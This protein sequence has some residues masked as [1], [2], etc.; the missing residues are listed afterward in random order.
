MD[1]KALA[2]KKLADLKVIAQ[3]IGL[4]NFENLKKDELILLITGESTNE[5][6]STET[7][8][9]ASPSPD[10]VKGKRPRK[11]AK[12]EVDNVRENQKVLFESTETSEILEQ[13]DQYN[14]IQNETQSVATAEESLS[15]ENDV[16]NAETRRPKHQHQKPSKNEEAQPIQKGEE[17]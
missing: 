17:N 7:T 6:K 11:P 10:N 4:S 14:E 5:E 3:T 16:P 15:Q 8:N 12:E 9:S 1:K 13:D 2:E